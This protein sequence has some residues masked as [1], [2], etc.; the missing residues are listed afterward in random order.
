MNTKRN[1]LGKVLMKQWSCYTWM[2]FRGM[3][4]SGPSERRKS[5]FAVVEASTK[6][7]AEEIY[8]QKYRDASAGRNVSVKPKQERQISILLCERADG[9][10]VT[11]MADF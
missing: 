11:H 5:H 1:P 7:Q 3:G 6:R 4:R 2:P 8:R 9:S 10:E